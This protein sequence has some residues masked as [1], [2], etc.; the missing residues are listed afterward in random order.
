LP[1][2]I[3][4]PE[5]DELKRLL[6]DVRLERGLTQ[7]ELAARLDVT[8]SLVSKV[9]QGERRLDLVELQAWC[10]ALGISLVSFVRRFQSSTRRN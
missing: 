10:G 2:S 9:E 8:Q 1:K 3:H 5:Y 4:S 7:S 6:R